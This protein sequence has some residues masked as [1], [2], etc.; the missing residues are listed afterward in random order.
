MAGEMH[1][2]RT[3]RP[4]P[5]PLIWTRTSSTPFSFAFCNVLSDSRGSRFG[6][7]DLGGECAGHLR[8]VRGSALGALEPRRPLQILMNFQLYRLHRQTE[9]DQLSTAPAALH[10]IPASHNAGK[11]FA[12][13]TVTMVLLTL[14]L[15]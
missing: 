3:A 10:D 12:S 2:K 11:P 8:G 9:D 6:S 7:S 13:V 5:M 4:E 14:A 15:T 1:A